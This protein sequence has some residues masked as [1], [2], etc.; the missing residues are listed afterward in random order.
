MHYTPQTYSYD[1]M[2]CF[3]SKYITLK[4]QSELNNRPVHG[5]HK[6]TK[7]KTLSSSPQIKPLK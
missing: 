2:L 6:K 4:C 1:V 5:Q 3:L 7:N